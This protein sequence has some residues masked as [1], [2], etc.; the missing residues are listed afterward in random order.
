MSDLDL[1][2]R[3]LR[4]KHP[5]WFSPENMKKLQQAFDKALQ[6][7]GV[8]AEAESRGLSAEQ[9]LNERWRAQKKQFV[10][11]HDQ[12]IFDALGTTLDEVID[13]LDQKRSRK[14][15][16]ANRPKHYDDLIGIALC[17]FRRAEES[18]SV[19]AEAVNMA[20]DDIQKETSRS[21]KR[22]TVASWLS[23]LAGRPWCSIP[24]PRK[25]K[26]SK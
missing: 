20:L 23:E 14:R 9:V 6:T 15:G 26:P 24:P 7:T 8:Y 10:A 18:G 12:S 3:W 17:A 22:D 25:K 4:L 11:S 13:A 19:F 1:L 21:I 2:D 5:D 16:G